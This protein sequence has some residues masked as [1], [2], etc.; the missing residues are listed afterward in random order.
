VSPPSAMPDLGV[1]E[2]DARNV[3]AYLATLSDD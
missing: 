3:T 2:E 1:Q